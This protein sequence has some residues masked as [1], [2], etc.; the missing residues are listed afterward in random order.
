MSYLVGSEKQGSVD[1][2]NIDGSNIVNQVANSSLVLV[3]SS[4]VTTH[5]RRWHSTTYILSCP[6]IVHVQNEVAV[7]ILLNGTNQMPNSSFSVIRCI[8][9]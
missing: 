2:S 7:Y 4:T 3:Y 8:N 1:Y 5:S 6:G 9:R